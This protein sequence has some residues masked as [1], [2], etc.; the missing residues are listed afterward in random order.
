MV[1]RNRCQNGAPGQAARAGRYDSTRSRPLLTAVTGPTSLEQRPTRSRKEDLARVAIRPTP[2]RSLV[3]R[4]PSPTSS[5]PRPSGRT[6]S[7]A[8]PAARS[9]GCSAASGS[10]QPGLAIRLDD[11]IEIDL[12]LTVAFGV[13]VAE[14]A[15]QVDSAVRYA[16][17]RALG[18]E[19]APPRRSTSTACTSSRRTAP[20]VRTDGAADRRSVRATSPTAGRTSPDGPSGL[21]RRR[22]ARGVPRRRRQPRGARRRDQRPQRLPGPRRRHRLEHVATVKAALDEA[23]AVAGQ[24]ADRIAAAISFG[25]LM[26]ARGNSGVITSQIFRGMAEG[27]GGK[28][29]VQ[30]PRPRPRPVARARG[31]PTARSRSRSRARS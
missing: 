31:P 1:L 19:V 29:P 14:V 17:R 3:T 23:E 26:G 18:R 12:D 20:A 11:G 15:R 21:R 2:G 8:S 28:T 5:A 22:P 16:L 30:R 6:A 7:P 9:P 13:P 24:P 25:A 4:A 10:A 27:L